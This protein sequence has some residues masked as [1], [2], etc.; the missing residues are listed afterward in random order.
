MEIRKQH[1]LR[2]TDM[3]LIPAMATPVRNLMMTNIK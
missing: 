1:S 2:T 3:M